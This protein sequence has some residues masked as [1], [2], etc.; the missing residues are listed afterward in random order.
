MA[1]ATDL[2]ALILAGGAG[3]RLR[4][5]T[6]A[7]AKQLVPVANKPILLYGLE[8]LV[9]AGV[10]D[11]GIIISPETGEDIKR[12]VQCWQDSVKEQKG[13]QIDAT[14]ILQDK[15]LGLAHAVK[16]AQPYLQNSSFAMYLGDNL[17]N[18]DLK[19]WVDGFMNPLRASGGNSGENAD[20][21]VDEDKIPKASILLKPVENPSS[22]GVAELHEDGRVKRLIEKP[23]HPPSDLALVGV[24]LFRPQIFDAIDQIQPS[25]RGELEITDAIQQL[26][27]TGYQVDCNVHEGWWL[28]TGKKDDLLSANQTILSDWPLSTSLQAKVKDNVTEEGRVLLGRNVTL[29]NCQL[30][31]PISLGDDVVIENSTIGPFVSI[32]AGSVIQDSHVEH[33]VLLNHCEVRQLS[34]CLTHSLMGHQCIITG[35]GQESDTK[36]TLVLADHSQVSSM[37]S[38]RASV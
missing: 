33:S 36:H 34:G 37:A 38:V 31:G 8:A 27:D 19:P 17:I 10:R 3:T 12:A 6:Y 4:P 28:D 20:G 1:V 18:A 15:P 22:F 35:D 14:F 21:S 24:Y 13:L 5:L 25:A 11:M 29:R 16:T 2:K 32:G 26:I 9:D 30:V 23:K 7:M